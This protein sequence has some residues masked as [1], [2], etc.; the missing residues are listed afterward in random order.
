MR[1]YS[2]A[3]I[4]L[5]VMIAAPAGALAQGNTAVTEA[6]AYDVNKMP[7]SATTTFYSPAWTEVDQT[8]TAQHEVLHA[9]GFA[10]IYEKLKA[11]IDAA[12]AVRAAPAT[13]ILAKLTP[14]SD[15]THIDPRAGTIDGFDQSKSVITP[16]VIKDTRMRAQEKNV[17]DA[18]FGW[19]GTN[20]KIKTVFA[21]TFSAADK[22]IIEDAAASAM[23]LL[24]SNGSGPEFTWTVKS[25]RGFASGL[26][27]IDRST[28]ANPT[29]IA[30]AI[31]GTERAGRAKAI[32]QALERGPGMADALRQQG[33]VPMDGLAPAPIDVV[34][35]ILSGERSGVYRTNSFGIHL[36]EPLTAAALVSLGRRAGF[37]LAPGAVIGKGN[38]QVYV[39]V[40]AGRD[41]WDVLGNCLSLPDISTVNLN[42]VEY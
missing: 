35:S 24:S 1:I 6:F 33:A 27:L 29:S 36:A 10:R 14:S 26:P 2:G 34:Y 40:D 30:A 5:L 20:M 18:G 15:G 8:R 12:N 13:R 4:A 9:I 16:S 38:P 3:I 19:V 37:H 32:A 28:P 21:S 11:R 25:A 22:R 42:Y 23:S 39:E 7:I 31:A 41:L 17:L